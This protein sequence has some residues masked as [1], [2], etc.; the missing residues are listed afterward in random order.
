MILQYLQQEWQEA[1]PVDFNKQKKNIVNLCALNREENP[2][3][4][5]K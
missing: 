1:H 3:Q 5:I 2:I 4:V